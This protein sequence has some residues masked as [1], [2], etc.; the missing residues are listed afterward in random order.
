MIAG[1]GDPLAAAVKVA[2]WPAATAWET[3]WVVTTG[4]LAEAAEAGAATPMPTA[5]TKATDATASC[6]RPRLH[7]GR[8]PVRSA[9]MASDARPT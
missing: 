2:V 9:A 3:G 1:A 7:P 4:A 6:H 5:A 8:H